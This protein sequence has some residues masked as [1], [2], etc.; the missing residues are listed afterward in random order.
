MSKRQPE[1]AVQ[2]SPQEGAGGARGATGPTLTGK[3]VLITGASSGIGRAVALPCAEAG[4]D[5]ALTYRANRRGADDTAESV[6]RHGRRAAVGRRGG[7]AG[8]RDHGRAGPRGVRP[9]GRMGEQRRCRHP[10]RRSGAPHLARKA[11]PAARGGSAGHG[12]RLME[13]GRPDAGAALRR[14]DPECVLGPRTGGRNE[15]RVRRS[16]LRRQ[17]RRVLVQPRPGPLS[18]AAHPRERTRARLDRDRVRRVPRRED[19]GADHAIDPAEPL[20]HPAGSRP[21]RGLSR[22]G[23][24]F[25]RHRPDVDD[26]RRG[27]RLAPDKETP[28][29]QKEPTYDEAQIEQKL[30]ELPGWW[31]ED[32]WI[33]RTYKTDGWPTTMML[34]NAI[35]YCSEAAYHH[36]DLSVTWGRVIVKLQ[37]HAAGGITDKDFELAR[38]IDE[39]VLWRPKGGALEGT[40]NKFVRSG[41]P[42]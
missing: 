9:R 41:D 32:G 35:G 40:P 22:L 8:P 33:R 26:Q 12:A 25:L 21:R 14:G 3:V 42:R 10:H 11:R 37:N 7:R 15:G 29:A 18:G 28:M 19:Q 38:K 34:V 5:L 39:T 4:A 13:G 31:Y 27:R 1:G 17:G 23:R 16:V 20:G 2:A 30:K 36:P 6:R 24:G